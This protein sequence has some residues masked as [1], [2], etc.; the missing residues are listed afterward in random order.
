M[1]STY[2]FVTS[3][4]PSIGRSAPLAGPSSHTLQGNPRQVVLR[5][6]CGL[7]RSSASG[8]LCGRT[9]LPAQPLRGDVSSRRGS[10]DGERPR[11]DGDRGEDRRRTHVTTAHGTDGGGS[12]RWL[13][14]V[15]R[16]RLASSSAN[17]P[18]VRRI[19]AG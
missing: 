1:I 18:V 8:R 11:V 9:R 13:S 6:G 3:A 5:D 7:A 16:A 12:C 4:L 17:E 15:A 10:Y 14:I 19:R 2:G